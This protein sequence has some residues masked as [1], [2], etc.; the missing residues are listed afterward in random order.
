M[1]EKILHFVWQMKLFDA[2]SLKTTE[3]APVIIGS[4]GA[5]NKDAGPDFL[6]ARIKIGDTN[7]AGHIEMHVR[8]SDWDRHDHSA[9]SGYDNV[10]A[11]SLIHI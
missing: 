3:G 2:L 10:I 6:N 1:N 8:S 11:L 7:W 9:D 5:L 4:T